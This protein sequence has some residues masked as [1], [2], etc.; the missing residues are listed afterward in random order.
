M[1]FAGTPQNLWGA[2]ATEV[3]VYLLGRTSMNAIHQGNYGFNW[4]QFLAGGGELGVRWYDM[5]STCIKLVRGNIDPYSPSV[6]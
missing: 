2:R 1:F 5:N 6:A 3:F 4:Y